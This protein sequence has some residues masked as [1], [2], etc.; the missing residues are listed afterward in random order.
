MGDT[1]TTPRLLRLTATAQPEQHDGVLVP[2]QKDALADQRIASFAHALV[3]AVFF[4]RHGRV[5][6]CLPAQQQRRAQ[7]LHLGAA[8]IILWNTLKLA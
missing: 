6:T 5:H 8:A 3:R 1:Q 7:G 2:D 4:Y